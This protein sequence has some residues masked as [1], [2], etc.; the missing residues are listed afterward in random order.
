[1]TGAASNLGVGLSW[2]ILRKRVLLGGRGFPV[3][4]EIFERRETSVAPLATGRY[5]NATL[6]GQRDLNET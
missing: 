6:R 4:F 2:K 1:M 5:E 3:V